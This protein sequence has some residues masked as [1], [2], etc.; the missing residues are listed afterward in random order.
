LN[1]FDTLENV[2]QDYLTYIRTFQRFANPRIQDW[3]TD[4]IEHGTLLWKPP[5]VQLSRPFA[6][7][8]GLEDLVEKGVLH[9]GVLSIFRTDTDDPDSPPIKPYRHQSEAIRRILGLGSGEGANVVVATCT[10]SGKSFAI[11]IPIVSEAMKMREQVV[12]ATSLSSA[13]SAIQAP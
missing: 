1:P 13:V 12:N 4:R 11:G 8:D 5:F 6:P 2:Q 3:V 9:P 7:G 10:G